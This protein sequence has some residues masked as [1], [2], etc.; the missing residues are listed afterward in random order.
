MSPRAQL[1]NRAGFHREVRAD[2]TLRADTV[3]HLGHQLAVR[4]GATLTLEAGT[5]VRAWGRHTAIVVEP[6]CCGAVCGF[7]AGPR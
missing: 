6:G 1:L 2:T 5:V 3:N 7:A 4:D